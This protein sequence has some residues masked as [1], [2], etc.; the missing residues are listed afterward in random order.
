MPPVNLE[1]LK[2]GALVVTLAIAERTR[3]SSPEHGLGL[4]D[5]VSSII[6][7]SRGDRGR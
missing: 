7:S 4:Q 3:E 6:I 5:V 2:P 1:D